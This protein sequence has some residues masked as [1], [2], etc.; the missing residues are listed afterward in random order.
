MKQ[1][2][3]TFLFLL[4]INFNSCTAFKKNISKPVTIALPD[5]LFNAAISSTAQYTK[6]TTTITSQQAVSAF[7]K[8]FIFEAKNTPNVTLLFGTDKADYVLRLKYLK[9][10]ESSKTE[11]INDT[12]SPYNG[13]EALLNVVSV[14]GEFEITETRNPTKKLNPCSNNKQ[15][16]ESETSNRN[17][18]DLITGANKDHTKYHTKTLSD[19]IATSLSED[20]GRRIWVPITRRIANQKD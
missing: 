2:L 7:L 9:I 19:N 13:M 11:K 17:L 12:K 18:D 16:S 5:T 20:V 14:T 1:L 8:G 15:R 10:E 6:Y 3:Y 4:A